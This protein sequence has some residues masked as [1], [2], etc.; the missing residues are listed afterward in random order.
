[1]A[2]PK[3][4]KNAL[5]LAGAVVLG[6]IAAL[7]S[8]SYIRQRVEEATA[9]ARVSVAEATVVVAKR[10]LAIGET[11]AASDIVTRSVPVD[12]IPADVVSPD[13]YPEFVGRMVRAPIKAGAPLSASTL[14]PVYDKFS[15][16]IAPGKIGYTMSVNENNSISGM[17]SPGDSVDI[18]LSYSQDSGDD[19]KQASERVAPLLKDILVLATG[20]RIGETPAGNQAAAGFSS[21]TLELDARQAEKL[22]LG[23]ETGKIRVLL[24][25]IKD[26]APL[27]LAG[28][29]EEALRRSLGGA[30]SGID[31][32]QYIIGGK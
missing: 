18:M 28:M 10:D 25:N 12:F 29:T 9:A 21:I 30:G 23:Q 17:I 13:R 14:V 24:R 7:L 8:V 20:T 2:L 27:G 1:M 3:L 6:L 19:A 31:G 4:N 5:F 26:N 32:V 15:R 16:V 22:T 11:L